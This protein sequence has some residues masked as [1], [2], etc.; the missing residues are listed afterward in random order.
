M[1]YREESGAISQQRFFEKYYPD[2][3]GAS[4]FQDAEAQDNILTKAMYRA[5]KANTV[6]RDDP[7]NNLVETMEVKIG[8]QVVSGKDLIKNKGR[9]GYREAYDEAIDDARKIISTRINSRGIQILDVVKSG[10]RATDK[11]IQKSNFTDVLED[12]GFPLLFGG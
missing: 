7:Y 10:V 9:Q 1:K 5:N 11:N 8:D 6:L 2:G 12:I 4:K 3:N